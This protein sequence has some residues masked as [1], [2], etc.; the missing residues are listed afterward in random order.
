MS[1]SYG[2]HRRGLRINGRL[3]GYMEYSCNYPAVW[4]RSFYEEEYAY[5]QAHYKPQAVCDTVKD[6]FGEGICVLSFHWLV[7]VLWEKSSPDEWCWKEGCNVKLSLILYGKLCAF[8][9]QRYEN[10]CDFSGSQLEDKFSTFAMNP[11][12]KTY[13]GSRFTLS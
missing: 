8:R 7:P 13:G 2:R 1:Q 12:C 4:S 3:N 9:L 11:L 10:F 5:C 6:F